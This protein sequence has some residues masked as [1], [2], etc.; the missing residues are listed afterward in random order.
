VSLLLPL[1][2]VGCDKYCFPVDG[3]SK[4]PSHFPSLPVK[5]IKGKENFSGEKQTNKFALLFF[6]RPPS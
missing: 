1:L 4:H 6:K 5:K 3:I 2:I